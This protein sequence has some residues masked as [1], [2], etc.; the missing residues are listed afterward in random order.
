MPKS[1]KYSRGIIETQLPDPDIK[2]PMQKVRSL[3]IELK[4]PDLFYCHPHP[5]HC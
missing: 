1:V 2:V 5:H 3:E 4:T